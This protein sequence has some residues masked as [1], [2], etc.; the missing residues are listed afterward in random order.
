MKKHFITYIPI[1]GIIYVLSTS[2]EY[3]DFE[4]RLWGK[5]VTFNYFSTM[6]IQ[7]LSLFPVFLI[8]PQKI[9]L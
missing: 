1:I 4:E 9:F 2:V 8:I 7:A 3:D 6:L 5:N